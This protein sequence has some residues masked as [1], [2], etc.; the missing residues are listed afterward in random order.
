MSRT[1]LRY[2]KQ[3]GYQVHWYGK[4]DL[5]APDSFASSVDVAEHRGSGMFGQNPY[6]PDDPRY[7]SFLY[8]RV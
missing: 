3:A 2:L 7:S 6:A 4:N 5:L 8:E 1:L